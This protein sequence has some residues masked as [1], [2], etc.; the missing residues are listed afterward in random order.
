[1]TRSGSK[2]SQAQ[3]GQ[4]AQ[5]PQSD[6]LST[7]AR[8]M[9]DTGQQANIVADANV[10]EEPHEDDL[11]P[12]CQILLCNPVTTQCR[13]T[14]CKSCMATW[15]DV[16]LAAP[17]TI[18]AV[19]EQPREF[20][21]ATGLEANCPMC[22]TRTSAALDENRTN[23]LRSKYPRSY[24][25]REAEEAQDER[26][27]ESV[28]TLTVYIGNEHRDI[29]P[30]PEGLA[31]NKHEWTFFVRPSRTDIIEEV[32]IHLHPTFRQNHI[33][34][35]RPPYQLTRVGWGYFT[36]TAS[37]ILKAGYSWVSSDAEDSPDGA[38]KGM[39]RLEWTLDFGSFEGTGAMG[40][41]RLKVKS[42]RGREGE[43]WERAS[44]EGERDEAEWGRMRRTY[45]RDGRYEPPTE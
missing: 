26:E 41:C 27:G 16:S 34:R 40:R 19:T 24:A 14:M 13:H 42:A 43:E 2:T 18:V 23:T 31:A 17:M 11:C 5:S 6:S 32:H 10:P 38:E 28:Q 39:L 37:V 7:T 21:A 15:A 8:N 9:S 4:A 44:E 25:E 22:R 45:E 30:D 33:V 29:D 20:D 36:I 1:M 35:S 12:I 3:H